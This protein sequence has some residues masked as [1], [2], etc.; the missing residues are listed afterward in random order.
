[1]NT[2]STPQFLPGGVGDCKAGSSGGRV[3]TDAGKMLTLDKGDWKKGADIF[4]GYRTGKRGQIYF[5]DI[6]S[7]RKTSTYSHFS[8]DFKG[9]AGRQRKKS[10]L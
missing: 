7:Q 9:R 8:S 2:D 10:P 5:P 4:S 1:M 3:K 6:R